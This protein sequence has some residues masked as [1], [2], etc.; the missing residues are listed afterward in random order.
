MG[1]ILGLMTRFIFWGVR[2]GGQVLSFLMGFSL[3]M[4]FS[5]DD[6]ERTTLLAR[7]EWLFAMTIFLLIDGHFLLIDGL[8]QSFHIVPL[9]QASFSSG[10]AA[11]MLRLSAKVFVIAMQMSAPVLV[12]IFMTN[13]SLAMLARM[14]PQMNVFIV[15]FPLTISIGM[16]TLMVI[17][18]AFWMFMKHLLALLREDLGAVLAILGE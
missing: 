7:F 17:S 1:L 4:A 10:L 8:A 16:I 11:L 2:F 9:T 13:V 12:T 5:S 3:A 18:P 15:G 6:L 14:M